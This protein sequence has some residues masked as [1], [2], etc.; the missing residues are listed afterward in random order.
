MKCIIAY[1]QR[2][3]CL[4]KYISEKNSHPFLVFF[5]EPQTY[6]TDVSSEMKQKVHSFKH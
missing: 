2:S 4:I 6:V 5:K 1:M 3:Q